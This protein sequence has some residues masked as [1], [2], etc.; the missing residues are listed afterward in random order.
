ML[1]FMML[2][3]ACAPTIDVQAIAAIVK[4]ESSFNPLAIGINGQEKLARQ[5][6]SEEEAVSTARWLIKNGYNIDMGLGQIN[7][8]NLKKVG[9]TVEEIFDPCKN[10]GAAAQ[11]LRTNYISAKSYIQSDHQA[12]LA[13]FSAYNTGS[14]SKGFSNGYVQKVMKAVDPI[15][16]LVSKTV[17]TTSLPKKREPPQEIKLTDSVVEKQYPLEPQDIENVYGNTAQNV[18]V[19]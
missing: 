11:I 9:L 2:A 10:I 3:Q 6:E 5:P 4:T 19:Y 8:S 18:M 15:P 7:G 16:V 13:S 14:F 1:G 12:L 17:K